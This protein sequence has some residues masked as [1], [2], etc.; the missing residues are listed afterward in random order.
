MSDLTGLY[1][2]FPEAEYHAHPAL[3]QSQAKVLLDCP[4][5]YRWQLD[6]PRE[7]TTAFDVGTAAHSKVLGVG[8]EVVVIPDEH[9][10]VDG[11]ASTK[12]A[13][14]FIAAA[15]ADGR[16]PILRVQAD[17]VDAMAE[18]VLAHRTARAILEREGD[19]ELS[20]WWVDGADNGAEVQCR[21]RFDRITTTLSDL[22]ALVDLKTTGRSAA[23]DAFTKA[24]VDYGYDLQATW[25]AH[26]FEAIT[27]QPA[28]FTFIVVEKDAPHL[29]AVHTLDEVF[30]ERGE[31]LRRNA[32]DTYA[33]CVAADTWPAHGDEIHILTPPRWAA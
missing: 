18:A 30:Q 12:A 28:T 2:G 32:I 23:P 1:A 13:K 27:G 21:A 16:T 3:S 5:R 14:E 11:K 29:V 15:R 25:Y 20:A 17:A 6:N 7:D 24:V 26:G 10:S 9:L 33:A 8:S 19:S 22:P 4:A 31:R